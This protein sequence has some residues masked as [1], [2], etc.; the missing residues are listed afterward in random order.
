MPINLKNNAPTHSQELLKIFKKA[1]KL[2]FFIIT[3]IAKNV[4]LKTMK[5]GQIL[6]QNKNL[7]VIYFLKL[8]S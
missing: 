1:Q 4:S 2:S 5:L 7:E 6:I 8:W 3:N